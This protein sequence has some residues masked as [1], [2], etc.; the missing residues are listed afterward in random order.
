MN[1]IDRDNI[2]KHIVW[3]SCNIYRWRRKPIQIILHNAAILRAT[4]SHRRP[5][6]C[7]QPVSSSSLKTSSRPCPSSW[8]SWCCWWSPCSSSTPRPAPSS[9]PHRRQAHQAPVNTIIRM[10]RSIAPCISQEHVVSQDTLFY[11]VTVQC[12]EKY[13]HG[14]FDLHSIPKRANHYS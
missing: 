1:D 2:K 8:T 13:A 10:L 4:F 3:S 11:W 7:P 6:H 5:R 9:P 12:L 14:Y